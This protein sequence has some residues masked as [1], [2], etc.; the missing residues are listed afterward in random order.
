MLMRAAPTTTK[1]WAV[2]VQMTGLDAA[3][4]R[5]CD[6]DPADEQDGDRD[7]PRTMLA[8]VE[9]QLADGDGDDEEARPPEARISADDEQGAATRWRARSP[10]V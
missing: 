8:G 10:R 9:D 1:I 4:D 3:G 7:Q 2:S 5:V 6:A